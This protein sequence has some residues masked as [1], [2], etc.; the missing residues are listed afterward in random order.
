[1]LD[2]LGSKKPGV[3]ENSEVLAGR[4]LTDPQLFGDVNAADTVTHQV[5]IDL[6]R[7]MGFRLFEPVED[8]Q[9]TLVGEGLDDCDGNHI[10]SLPTNEVYVKN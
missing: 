10:V 7:K 1:M 4:R 8:L 2:P 6:G 3:H 9:A 5:T